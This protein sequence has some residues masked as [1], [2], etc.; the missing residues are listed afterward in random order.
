MTKEQ[1]IKISDETKIDLVNSPP[2][3]TQASIEC[4]DAIA[5][6]LSE[7]EFRGFCK[8]NALKYIWRSELK[9]DSVEN[10]RKANWYLRR[11]IPKESE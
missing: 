6:A 1:S 7:D 8:G 10:L 3:Y 9:G 4:I 5:A 2:H 11:L